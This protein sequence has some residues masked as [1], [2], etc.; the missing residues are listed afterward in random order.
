MGTRQVHDLPELPKK[1]VIEHQTYGCTCKSCGST[2]R[3][4]FPSHIKAPT[5]YGPNI[6]FYILYLHV[7]QFISINR[8]KQLLKEIF[9]VE[10]STGTIQSII[11]RK[12][13]EMEVVWKEI[14]ELIKTA[15]VKHFDE[16]G[17]RVEGKLA[18]FHIACT[19]FLCQFR[20]GQSRG[21]VM[22]GA[23]GT[24]VHDFWKS[25]FKI[26]TAD[27]SLCL[28]HLIRELEAEVERGD[29]V[30]SKA[31]QELLQLAN[32]ETQAAKEKAF[33]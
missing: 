21:D 30:W 31:L 27:H 22:Q 25:Y 3:A 10:I 8:T 20:L 33:G 15:S 5:Q 4:E 16:T 9:N 17:M 12:S 28:A 6:T 24:I 26:D 29:K 11:E 1:I 7:G 18:W 32:K 14:G 2:T 23:T 13:Q 19:T